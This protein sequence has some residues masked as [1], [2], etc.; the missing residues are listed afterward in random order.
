[1]DVKR[2]RRRLRHRIPVGLRHY[3]KLI[4]G[5]IGVVATLALVIGTIRVSALVASDAA[6]GFE[7]NWDIEGTVDLF[8]TSV[9]HKISLDF[10]STDYE[11]MVETYQ[12]S[13]EKEWIKAD[14]TIDGVTID[15]VGIRLKGNS[16]L[17]SLSGGGEEAGG[18]PGGMELPEGLELPE[19]MAIPEGLMGG[20]ETSLSF[21]EPETLPWLV[22]FSKYVDGQV[23]QGNRQISIRDEGWNSSSALS[24]A[25]AAEMVEAS[26]E[27]S[28]DWTYSKV[29]VNGSEL[30][31]RRIVDI[32]DVTW[33]EDEY[34]ADAGVL[35]KA[36]AGGS[37]SYQGEDPAEY[38]DDFKQIT[39]EGA[40]DAQ[41]IISFLEW[42]DGAD[43]ATFAAELGD[44]VDIESFANYVALQNLIVNTDDMAGPGS[45]YYLW[46]DYGTELLSVIAWDLDLALGSADLGPE[47][48]ASIAG[49]MGGLFGGD[50][51][52][53]DGT[54][55]PGGMALPEG[56]GLP[57]GIEIPEEIMGGHPLKERFLEAE[58]FDDAYM[59]A[60]RELYDAIYTSGTALEAVDQ[61]AAAAESSGRNVAEDAASLQAVIQER[62]EFLAI[63]LGGE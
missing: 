48:T 33:A 16:T 17:A 5:S 15:D 63:A 50:E 13:G 19:G 20:G 54:Q 61:A 30:V 55:P 27:P 56:M 53:A 18:M 21:D 29:S 51:A 45:N 7:V 14:I 34:G 12:D 32:M 43:D 22:D 8:D 10:D 47:E 4:A 44:W 41:P 3:W 62:T 28:Y 25:V 58:A 59:S 42:F 9:A 38:E 24:E 40:A 49:A 23:Y 1:M 11:E 2:P 37:F 35:Y 36:R 6:E 60:Y 57:E 31:S 46:Y 52:V 26:G 39:M